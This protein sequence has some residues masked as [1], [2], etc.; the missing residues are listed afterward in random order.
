MNFYRAIMMAA[1]HIEQH[2]ES[3]NYFRC[4][5]P[6]CGTEGCAL[7]WIGYFAGMSGE[8]SG[9]AKAMGLSHPKYREWQ[10][11]DR[12]QEIVG[13]PSLSEI[14]WGFGVD[15]QFFLRTASTP[16]IARVLR[17]YAKKYHGSDRQVAQGIPD[18]VRSIFNREPA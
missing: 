7:G 15:E 10:F 14:G 5:V 2:P 16:E 1:D 13:A 6:S 12:I 4:T 9:V 11:Y 8:I 17:I 3:W 18:S